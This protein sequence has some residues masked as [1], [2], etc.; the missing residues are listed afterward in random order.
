[1]D[2][3]LAVVQLTVM[4]ESA[5]VLLLNCVRLLKVRL[6]TVNVQLGM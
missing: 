3:I 6:I 5:I 1:M 4:L 2:I